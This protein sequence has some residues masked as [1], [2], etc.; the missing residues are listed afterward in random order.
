[1]IKSKQEG[2]DT[3][4]IQLI[5]TPDPGHRTWKWQNTIKHHIQESQ[6][7]SHFPEGDHKSAMNRQES[8]TNT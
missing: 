6:E 5:T 3:K 1:M 4:S 8:I 7:V 2:K